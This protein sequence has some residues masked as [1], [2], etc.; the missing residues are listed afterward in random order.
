MKRQYDLMY[1]VGDS[2]VFAIGQSDD[3]EQVVTKE[4]RFSDL[5]SSHYNLPCYNNGEAGAGNEYVTR[6]LY[7]DLYKCHRD[8]LNPFVVMVF[9]DPWRKEIYSKKNNKLMIISDLTTNFF[10]EYLLNHF[11]YHVFCDL[12][13]NL[14]LQCQTVCDKFNFDY[15]Q[16]WS[17]TKIL[18][19]PFSTNEKTLSERLDLIAGEE[20]RFYIPS[21]N[22]YGH[23]NILGHRKIADAFIKKIDELYS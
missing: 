9:S 6:T 1:F 10:Q 11:N 14:V 18:D 16:A 17:F 20:G 22:I 7:N 4:N 2:W 3:V 5:V 8:G 19:I 21:L 12:S 13:A 23:P 15:V